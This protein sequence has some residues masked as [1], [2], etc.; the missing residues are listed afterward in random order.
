MGVTKEILIEHF[1]SRYLKPEL[2][3]NIEKVADILDLP[4]VTFKDSS[5]EELKVLKEFSITTIRDLSKKAPRDINLIKKTAQIDE[6]LF[7]MHYLAS[8]L[9][10]RSWAQRSEYQEKPIT[11]V[12][13]MGLDNAGKSTLISLLDKKPISKALNQEPTYD[14]QQTK[15]ALANTETVCW[16]FAG[17]IHFRDDYILYPERYFLHIN[18]IIFVFD[19]QDQDRFSEGIEYLEKI[20]KTVDFL[21][22]DPYFLFML[23][24][25]DPELR[26]NSDVEIGVNFLKEQLG[27]CMKTKKFHY[28]MVNSSI[29]STFKENPEV[30]SFMKDVFKEEKDNP[31][32][33]LIDVMMKL[34]NALFKIGEKTLEG[35]QLIM[36]IIRDQ[37]APQTNRSLSSGVPGAVQEERFVRPS[38]V[39]EAA[40]LK[41]S[42]V[43]EGPLDASL[44][45]ELKTMFS[46]VGQNPTA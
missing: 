20:L 36:E 33:L 32:M 46:V 34:T 6:T 35:Q 30:I 31:N 12:C 37:G 1:R 15:F 21:G 38:Q 25:Y 16:D 43:V 10:S 23:H 19:V 29:Y 7:E 8:T 44:L 39:V 40:Q 14:V 22:E 45:D 11:K 26:V 2:C 17:Q 4:V 18:V 5:P 3:P 24:K 27:E 28:E 13:F 41:A 9:I 42:S